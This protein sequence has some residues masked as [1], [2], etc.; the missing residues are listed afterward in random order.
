[1]SFVYWVYFDKVGRPEKIIARH[2]EEFMVMLKDMIMR[3]DEMPE[4]IHRAYK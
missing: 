3:T 1:M 2:T 4:W